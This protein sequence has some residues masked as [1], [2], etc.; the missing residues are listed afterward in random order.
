MAALLSMI[1]NLTGCRVHAAKGLTSVL[2]RYWHISIFLW[3]WHSNQSS[4]FIDQCPPGIIT[5]LDNSGAEIKPT[6]ITFYLQDTVSGYILQF[7]SL[8]TSLCPLRYLT[9]AFH[10]IISTCDRLSFTLAWL[11]WNNIA[12]RTITEGISYIGENFERCHKLAL[13]WVLFTQY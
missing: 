9:R 5:L 11:N 2:C 12:W 8:E 3:H 7:Y 4:I 6:P 13:C 1:G 10:G